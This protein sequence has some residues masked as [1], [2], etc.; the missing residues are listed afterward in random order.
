MLEEFPYHFVG[1]HLHFRRSMWRCRLVWRCINAGCVELFS[2]FR[3][4]VVSKFGLIS[5]HETFQITNLSPI[6]WCA[7]CVPGRRQRVPDVQGGIVQGVRLEVQP[8]RDL[9][10]RGA[11]P[12]VLQRG[13]GRN[14]LQGK[15][16]LFF[17]G[18]RGAGFDVFRRSNKG[19]F[20]RG[21]EHRKVA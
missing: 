21:K 15:G 14:S 18:W 3:V 5:G 20:E 11:S 8:G 2:A 13:W 10:R 16:C 17:L 4:S 7:S 12:A 1:A 9:R 19:R 6:V